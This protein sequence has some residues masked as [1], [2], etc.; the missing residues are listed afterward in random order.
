MTFRF[1]ARHLVLVL[2]LSAFFS[3]KKDETPNPPAAEPTFFEQVQGRWNAKLEAPRRTGNVSPKQQAIPS[4]AAVEFFGDSTYILAFDYDPEAVITGKFR[5]TDSATFNF[6]IIG[7][8]TNVK[9]EGDSIS[10]SIMY[11]DDFPV[12]VK[13]G[14]AEALT[15]SSDIKPLLKNWLVERD[16]EDGEDL[17]EDLGEDSKVSFFF[18][19]SGSFLRKVTNGQEGY[20][21]FANW[22]WH[23]SVANAFVPYSI[24]G[25]ELTDSYFKILSI[26]STSL[27]IQ[28]VKTVQGQQ[29]TKKYVLT[30]E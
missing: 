9:L 4:V 23:A 6:D 30:A 29:E 2:S 11:H 13:A 16:L 24:Y 3:C 20:S 27:T 25:Y 17:Y 28:E 12:H 22:K 14:K 19:P 26:S 15:I 21:Q 8:A 1:N 10:F 7:A 18:S 5:V